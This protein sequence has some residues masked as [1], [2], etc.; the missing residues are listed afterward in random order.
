MAD[1]ASALRA[2]RTEVQF[3]VMQ[4]IAEV[5]QATAH[6]EKIQSEL[7]HLTL[8][9]DHMASTLNGAMRRP[10]LNPAMIETLRRLYQTDYQTLSDVKGRLTEARQQEQ[11]ARSALAAL[12]NRERSLDRA[13]KAEQRKQESRREVVQMENADDM[14]LQRV[15]LS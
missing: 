8:R 14:W 3:E 12:R 10:Q 6:A 15:S 9:C 4:A 11:Q 5:A 1:T 2:V 13:L 7:S